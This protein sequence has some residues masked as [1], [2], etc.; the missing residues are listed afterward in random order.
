MCLHLEPDCRFLSRL[1][2][3]D[4]LRMFDRGFWIF[5]LNRL[6]GEKITGTKGIAEL[7]FKRAGFVRPANP[8]REERAPARGSLSKETALRSS[9]LNVS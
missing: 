4:A 2:I 3:D 6:F 5:T 7:S 1:Q 9:C 8:S